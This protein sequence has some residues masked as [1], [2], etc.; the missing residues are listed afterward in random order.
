[1]DYHIIGD[2]HLK[3]DNLSVAKKLFDWTVSH[4]TG[5]HSGMNRKTVILLGDIYETK[6]ILRAEAQNLFYK[7]VSDLLKHEVIVYIIMGNHDYVNLD[8]TDHAFSFL[9]DFKN[10]GLN[11]IDEVTVIDNGDICLAPYYRDSNEFVEKINAAQTNKNATLFCHQPF[12]GAIY[13]SAGGLTEK[14]ECEPAKVRDKFGTV[15]SGHIHLKQSLENIVYVGTPYSQSFGEANTPKMVLEIKDGKANWIDTATI[16]LPR[17]LS[18]EVDAKSLKL[19]DNEAKEGDHVKYVITGTESDCQI[20]MSKIDATKFSDAVV[21][22]KYT[23]S[24]IDVKIDEHQSFVKM[25]DDYLELNF[26]DH[27]HVELARS[28]GKE[29][30]IKKHASL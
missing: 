7:F 17:H 25:L 30:F 15:Y 26:K 2:T 5:R 29:R 16:G 12:Q 4:V 9:E 11:I 23:D 14:G 24:G 1:M 13:N 22:Y 10:E 18:I 20:F 8:C 28:L 6:S 21:Q 27:P 3:T 19:P